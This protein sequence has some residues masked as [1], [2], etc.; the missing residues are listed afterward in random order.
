MT[1]QVMSETD[2]VA[3]SLCRHVDA[4]ALFVEGAA[5]N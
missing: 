5:Q 2:W 3:S 4:D 1:H